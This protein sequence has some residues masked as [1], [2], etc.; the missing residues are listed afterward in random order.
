M[1]LFT[2]V[3]KPSP[4]NEEYKNAGGAYI[5]VWIDFKE[6]EAAEAIAKFYIEDSDWV[7]EETGEVSWVTEEEIDSDDDYLCFMEAK[8]CGS[9]LVFHSWPEND[10]IKH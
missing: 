7:T 1:F 3:A 10:G 2:I 5:N 6:Q 4:D 8:E 9:C